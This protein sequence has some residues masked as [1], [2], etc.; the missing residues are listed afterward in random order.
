[1]IYDYKSDETVQDIITDDLCPIIEDIESEFVKLR[2]GEHICIFAPSKAAKEIL[3][4]ILE[5]LED[6]FVHSDSH[7]GLLYDDKNRVCF[8]IGYDGMIF[9]EPAE[10]EK[11]L[12]TSCDGVMNY[13]HDSFTKKELDKMLED[14]NPILVFGLKE[15][16]LV[17]T[18]NE[19]VTLSKGK[20]GVVHGFSKRWSNSDEY[21]NTYYSSYSHYSSD[22]NMVKS[23]AKDFG[24][25]I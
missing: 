1:M 3:G 17:S 22:E 14:E 24:I 2:R 20:D 13:V 25:N 6:V 21:G 18:K 19:S 23:I 15:E 11:G 7:N 9:I 16:D 5:D 8:T 12:M 4:N 10:C